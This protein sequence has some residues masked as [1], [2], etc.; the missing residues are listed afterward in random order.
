MIGIVTKIEHN[1]DRD[2]TIVDARIS[3]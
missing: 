2:F 3:T 1:T